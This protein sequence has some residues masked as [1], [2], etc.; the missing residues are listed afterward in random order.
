MWAICQREKV[1]RRVSTV[2]LDNSRVCRSSAFVKYNSV[3]LGKQFEKEGS[4][5]RLLLLLEK[6]NFNILRCHPNF[7]EIATTP[8]G[9]HLTLSNQKCLIL[10]PN[11]LQWKPL[12]L[13]PNHHRDLSTQ[14][15]Q[16][17]IVLNLVTSITWN[18]T[19]HRVLSPALIS[20]RH[21][22]SRNWRQT[23]EC[24]SSRL[25]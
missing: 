2:A 19:K 17:F 11:F 1:T 12:R 10:R 3:R 22:K 18:L 5:P 25:P 6:T 15:L 14:N 20:L 24:R 7:V 9:F 23:L 16:H 8:I 13:K 21:L 4:K